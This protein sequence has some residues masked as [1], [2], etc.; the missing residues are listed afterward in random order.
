MWS[1]AFV[2]CVS[3]L[4]AS[5]SSSFVRTLTTGRL[6]ARVFLLVLFHSV[7]G[8]EQNVTSHVTKWN[9]DAAG[10]RQRYQ[11]RNKQQKDIDLFDS[12]ITQTLEQ[13]HENGEDAIALDT[14][15]FEYARKTQEYLFVDFFASWYDFVITKLGRWV[16]RTYCS[17]L[18]C[19]CLPSVC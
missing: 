15:T 16:R 6:F 11:G 14:E 19:C 3:A 1:G 8:T 13:L 10:V 4:L 17:P 5:S 7:L 18:L 2:A 12:A 9:V